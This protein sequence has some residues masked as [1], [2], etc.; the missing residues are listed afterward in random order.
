MQTIPIADQR[1][2][3]QK[4]AGCDNRNRTLD[5]IFIHGLGGDSWTTW[6]A[7]VD[8]IESFWPYWIFEDFHNLG[9]WT[10]GYTTSST[11]WK[12]ES[13]PLGDRGNQILDSLVNEGIGERPTVFITH[14][15][16]GIL[17]KQTLRNALSFSIPRFKEIA[18]NTCGIMFIATPHSGANIASF[19][20]FANI[21]YR[22]NEDVEELATHSSPLRELHRWFLNT[23]IEEH[24][25]VCRTYAESFEIKP[26]LPWLNVKIPKGILV[27]D[28]TSSEPN[29]KNEC[30]I[31]L[32]EDH[33]SICK[34]INK[35]K[36]LYK[37]VCRFI[38]DCSR[39]SASYQPPI[40]VIQN[41][42]PLSLSSLESLLDSQL[43]DRRKNSDDINEL[44]QEIQTTRITLE[45]LS[46]YIESSLQ[47]LLRANHGTDIFKRYNYSFEGLSANG[48]CRLILD[49]RDNTYWNDGKG[50]LTPV[51]LRLALSNLFPQLN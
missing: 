48:L 10:L 40:D 15:M 42:T 20:K 1:R 38:K 22:T 39:I 9:L 4:I 7:D 43:A 51:E 3:L 34:P 21:L 41:R 32:E 35:S 17:I 44:F 13:M 8:L 47:V 46:L 6:M 19:A 16:G 2:G 18:S 26:E 49:V 28:A 25:V 33:I 12:S 30:A 27:V 23:Y 37:G 36:Q 14:S 11:K 24:E 45:E 50:K 5:I 31:F 29:I